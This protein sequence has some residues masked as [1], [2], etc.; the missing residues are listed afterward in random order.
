M[1]IPFLVDLAE[2][3]DE[4]AA[5]AIY[6]P[7]DYCFTII[8]SISA[9]HPLQ[10]VVVKYAQRPMVWGSLGRAMMPF[11]PR[12]AV[13]EALA[14]QGPPHEPGMEPITMDQLTAE[15]ETIHKQGCFVATSPSALG[16]TGTAAPV[17][18]SRGQLLGSI[19]VAV[20]AVRYDPAQ[21]EVLSRAVVDAARGLSDSL[22][23]GDGQGR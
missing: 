16:T 11:L 18:N 20:P 22:G 10:Y 2:R 3:F 7:N 19:G 21:Q 23:F 4:T 8:D 14:R 5:F 17:F 1:R 9:K 12:E 15:F 13:E 6:L